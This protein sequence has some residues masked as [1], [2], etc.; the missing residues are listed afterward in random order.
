MLPPFIIEEIRKREVERQRRGRERPRLEVPLPP[1][2]APEPRPAER[3]D[4]ETGVAI[5]DVL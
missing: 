2:R 5:I 3:P 4:D 1:R